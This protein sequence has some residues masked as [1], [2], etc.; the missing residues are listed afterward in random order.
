MKSLLAAAAFVAV[1]LTTSIASA[2]SLGIVGGNNFVLNSGFDL[3]ATT[4][5]SAGDTVKRWT[6]NNEAGGG[7]LTG[8]PTTL[9]FTYLGSEAAHF[10]SFV[11]TSSGHDVLFDNENSSVYDMATSWVTSDGLLGFEFETEYRVC[12]FIF[13]KDVKKEAENDGDIDRGLS[14]AL[15]QDTDGSLIALFGDGSGD[16]DMDDMAVRISVV[17]VPA[18]LPLFGAALL[19]M[20]FLARRRKQKAALQA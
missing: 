8:A 20:G 10:N 1:A 13:C 17:P 3:N 11:D 6:R 16:S 14:I 19:G 18:A 5:L 9:K 15:F 7:I 2:A 12:F 4:G